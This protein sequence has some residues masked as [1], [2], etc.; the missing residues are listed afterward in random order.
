MTETNLHMRQPHGLG[1]GRPQAGFPHAAL[2]S[3]VVRP[4]P[5]EVVDALRPL[6]LSAPV[7]PP[8]PSSRFYR[9]TGKRIFDLAFVLVTAPVALFLIAISAL[10]LWIEGGS[11][12]YRQ[13]R[14]GAGGSVFRILKLRTMVRDADARLEQVLAENDDL[15]RE[16]DATQKL[17]NDPRITRFGA[18]LR[19]TS[20]DELPQ[21]WNVLKG[22]MSLVGPRPM[23][24]DQLSI[25]G[26]AH[27]YFALRPGI[28]GLWQVSERNESLFKLRV[29][30]DAEYDRCLSLVQD[31][32]VLLLTV[33]AVVKRTGY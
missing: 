25:Y 7:A 5:A 1:G 27:H 26:D 11:P 22:D 4:S 20:L 32:K 9:T 10:L 29:R 8:L 31:L 6:N 19:K 33:G 3:Y 21:L 17:K 24:V 15:R 30:L 14:L 16:W 2:L 23:M 13:E 12:F 28:T 18:F